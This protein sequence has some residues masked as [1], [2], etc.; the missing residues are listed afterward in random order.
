MKLVSVFKRSSKFSF[1]VKVYYIHLEINQFI[2]ITSVSSFIDLPYNSLC[3]IIRLER[4]QSI[5]E[6]WGTQWNHWSQCCLT[7]FIILFHK[8]KAVPSRAISFLTD[9]FGGHRTFLHNR[10]DE[11]QSYQLTC[12]SLPDNF[13]P[14]FILTQCVHSWRE[15]SHGLR[16]SRVSTRV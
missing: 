6:K 8:R 2:S 3:F 4:F 11:I 15:D 16:T 10:L 1:H 12:N 9:S 7:C 14:S 5:D 13:F